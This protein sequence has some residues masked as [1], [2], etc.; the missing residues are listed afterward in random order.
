[1]QVSASEVKELR[2]RTGAGFMDCKE[3]LQTAQGDMEKALL[4]LR[5]KGLSKAARKAER[6]ASEGVVA[7]Y[8]HPGSRVGVLLEV[9]C[10]T[11][12]VARNSEFQELVK[13]LAMQVAASKPR[14]VSREDVPSQALEREKEFLTLQARETGKPDAIVE[15][16]VAGRMEKFFKENCLMEQPFIKDPDT[17]VA[18]HIKGF[19]AKLGENIVVRR[20]ERY[21]LGESLDAEPG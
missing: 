21:E 5:Q 15:K 13:E 1:M 17:D 20:F 7:S 10:E 6:A 19:M 12:F 14:W 3:A 2:D 16:M 9:N 4:Y 18:S 8:I 11:D